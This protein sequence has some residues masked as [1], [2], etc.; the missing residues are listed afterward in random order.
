MRIEIL[1]TPGC[2][3]CKVVERYLE[4]MGLPYETVDITENP[5]YLEK[6]PIFAAPG[7]VVDGR[8]EFS[9]TPGRKALER[10]LGQIMKGGSE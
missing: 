4:E 2:Q 10:R 1:T 5:E 6:Y 8:L 3:G 7:V 9:G